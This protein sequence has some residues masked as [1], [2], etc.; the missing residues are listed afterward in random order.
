MVMVFRVTN[1]KSLD[2]K[3]KGKNEMIKRDSMMII[4]TTI[5]VKSLG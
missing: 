3:D 4:M 2:D 5:F 1:K